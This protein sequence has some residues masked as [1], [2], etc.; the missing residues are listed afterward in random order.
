MEI[1][2]LNEGS[3]ESF[4]FSIIIC[5]MRHHVFSILVTNTNETHWLFSIAFVF[6]FGTRWNIPKPIYNKNLFLKSPKNATLPW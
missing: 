2:W 5:T 4:A 1:S 3:V 6:E